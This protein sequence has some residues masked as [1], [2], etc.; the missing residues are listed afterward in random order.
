M[1][2]DGRSERLALVGGALATAL[3]Y[4]GLYHLNGWLFSQAMINE[5]VSWVFLPAAVR[6]LAVLLFGWA[7]VAGL[8]AGSVLVVPDY[9]LAEPV[10]CVTLGVLSSFPALVAARWVQHRLQVPLDLG[11]MRPRHLMWFGLAGGLAN[12]LGHT[13]YFMLRAG[14][15]QPLGGFLPM[16]VGDALGTLV[17]LYLGARLTRQVRLPGH[18]PSR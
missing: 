9:V 7:G 3:A 10:R 8:F 15:L 18:S 1:S 6:M 4:I 17:V 11:G 5:N 13:L 2:A 12:S 16:L 14:N